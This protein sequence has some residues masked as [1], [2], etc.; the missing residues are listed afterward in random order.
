MPWHRRRARSN[1]IELQR[2]NG[3]LSTQVLQLRAQLENKT[4]YATV[5]EILLRQRNERIDELT[6]EVDQLREYSHDM[7]MFVGTMLDLN[8]RPWGAVIG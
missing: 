4:R 7:A 6:A 1:E 5:L 2:T 8:D 3:V